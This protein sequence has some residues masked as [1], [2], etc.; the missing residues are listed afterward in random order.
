MNNNCLN[1]GDLNMIWRAGPS[2]IKDSVKIELNLYFGGFWKSLLVGGLILVGGILCFGGG[3][4]EV[5][6]E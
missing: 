6:D 2:S 3:D 5:G 4:V 1:I